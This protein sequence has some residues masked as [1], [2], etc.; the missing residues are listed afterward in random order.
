MGGLVVVGAGLG[1]HD[2]V[3]GVMDNEGIW[4]KV[5]NVWTGL[6]VTGAPF[7]LNEVSNGVQDRAAVVALTDL[8]FLVAF[9][10]DTPE[11]VRVR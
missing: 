7:N 3:G 8:K 1:N 5:L 11:R 9:R 2:G 10:S 6:W 4:A